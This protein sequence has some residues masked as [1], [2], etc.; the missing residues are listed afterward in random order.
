MNVA[1]AETRHK[2]KQVSYYRAASNGFDAIFIP[3]V[4]MN[5][6]NAFTLIELLVVIAIIAILIGLLLPA[7][8]KV[9]AAAAKSSCANN[10]KQIGLAIHNFE[11]SKTRLPPGLNIPITSNSGGVFPSNSHYT[12]GRIG[13][14][15][16]GNIFASWMIL[17]LP[18]MEQD[19]LY[20]QL[21][22]TQRE[23]A[24]A[25]GVNAK[26]FTS[27]ASQVVNNYLCPSDWIPKRVYNY[28]GGNYAVNSY[29]A[30]AGVRSWFVGN[31]SFDGVF[32]IN[33]RQ[34]MIG[35][36]RN[37]GTSNTFM[38][39]E[40]FSKDD[41]WP[42]VPERRGWAWSSYNGVQD[43]L[44]G[45]AVPINYIIP[46]S[47]PTPV[48]FTFQD[49]RLTAFGSGH[50]RGANFVFCDGS[51]RFVTLTSTSDLVVLQRLA[52]PSDGEVVSVP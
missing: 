42:D 51:V 36:S 22:L 16:E 10:L 7:V 44:G 47:A 3:G 50:P 32:Q 21:D 52:R 5:R 27:P 31:A 48:S 39:G 25:N 35:I 41:K 24:N 26:G 2:L 19:P 40:R 12:S 15:P 8:Q 11:A 6:R 30:N 29:F 38:V 14:P 18:S 46:A 37:D 33:S 28:S 34:T 4:A 45:T 20:N 23:S 49:D 17:I 13:L 43:C 9:R 1:A